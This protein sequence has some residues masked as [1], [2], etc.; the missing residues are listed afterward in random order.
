MLERDFIGYGNDSPKTEWPD[1]SIL[2]ISLV[3]NYEEGAERSI[4]D[5]D[6]ESDPQG[7]APARTPPSVRNI[8]NESY[9]EYGSRVGVWRLLDIFDSHSV[10][11]T[12]FACGKALERNTK[13]AKEI[14]V[15][16]HEVCSH[17]YKWIDNF[18]LSREEQRQDML[19]SIEAIKNTTG[20]RPVG[21][22][23][24]GA[25]VDTLTLAAEE[26]GFIYDSS[27]S[28]ED[29]PYF[30]ETSTGKF[31][32]IPYSL[33][34]N[35]YRYWKNIVGPDQFYGYLKAT[36][37]QLYGEALSRPK[38]MSIGLHCRCS[39]LPARARAIE[40]FISYAGSFSGVWFAR[41]VDIARWW[42]EKYA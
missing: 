21:Y 1:G 6:S 10:P 26:G 24:R 41:R 12:F 5:G 3:V 17:G 2:A 38:M 15:R 8:M 40:E 33:D 23:P 32:T 25:S 34:C 42:W 9:F 16:G 30:T 35:D 19:R 28:S 13:V 18:N 20:K 11:V 39:G 27:T 4:L 31:L 29:L 36:F 22:Y 37:D 14:I 7:E